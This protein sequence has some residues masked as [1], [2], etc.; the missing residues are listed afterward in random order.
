[1]KTLIGVTKHD[2]L[3]VSLIL[4]NLE[5]KFQV[6]GDGDRV[7]DY[8]PIILIHSC[9]LLLRHK[10]F[11]DKHN[12]IVFVFDSPTECIKIDKINLLDVKKIKTGY[13]YVFRKIDKNLISNFVKKSGPKKIVLV[14]MDV[15]LTLLKKSKSGIL[16]PILS[17]LYKIPKENREKYA[18]AI[19]RWLANLKSL[20]S[21]KKEFLDINKKLPKEH[22]KL[23]KVLTSDRFNCLKKHLSNTHDLDS[24]QIKKL[25]KKCKISTYDINFI[26]SNLNKKSKRK[27]SITPQY[28]F[29]KMR[30]DRGKHAN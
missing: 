30:K 23:F 10:K 9:H 15:S 24:L 26:L 22:N 20:D 11:L 14:D 16:S 28:L 18:H 25:T 6:I 12:V 8:P 17:F 1:M 21:L 2:I 29:N 19:Y 13:D 27:I 7:H 4:K 3:S 5:E